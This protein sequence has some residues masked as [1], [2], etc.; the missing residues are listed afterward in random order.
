M[1][2]SIEIEQ[3]TAIDRDEIIALVLHCQNNESHLNLTID[4]QP[5]LLDI[6]RNY[7]DGGGQFWVAKSGG[8]VAGTIALMNEGNGLGVLKKF[9]VYKQFRG[10]PHNLGQRLFTVLLG[11]AK[12]NGFK[13]IFLDTP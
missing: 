10:T 8:K 4:D 12:S 11:F 9:F 6:Q 13:T 2:E 3:F 7:I 5:D 1:T